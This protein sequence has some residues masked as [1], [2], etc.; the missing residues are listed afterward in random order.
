MDLLREY[1]DSIESEYQI[2]SSN[3]VVYSSKNFKQLEKCNIINNGIYGYNDKFYEKKDRIITLDK[4][5]YTIVAYYDVSKY[6]KEI[7]K[8]KTDCLTKLPNRSQIEKNL[9]KINN[10]CVIVMSDIDD[11]KKVNDMYG[12]QVGDSV[13]RLMGDLI[14][15][16]IGENDFA[17]RYGGEEFLMIF[18]TTDVNEVKRKMDE[19]NLFLNQ[20]T[21][22]LNIST[23]IGIY[24]F[25]PKV[26]KIASAI[27]KAD[28]ALY[29]VKHNGKNAS[30]IYDEIKN[31]GNR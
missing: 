9:T 13:I 30:I 12:H 28:E 8:S 24:K 1:L 27:R 6:A 31:Y 2:I 21:K 17:G 19:F 16:L 3:K 22:S 20:Y 14:R 10:E 11:F 29:F 7:I 15:N 23:S 25:N 18:D 4:V 26:E 5:E